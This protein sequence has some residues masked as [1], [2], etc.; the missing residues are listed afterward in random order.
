MIK[1]VFIVNNP[2]ESLVVLLLYMVWEDQ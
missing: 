2:F 1:S